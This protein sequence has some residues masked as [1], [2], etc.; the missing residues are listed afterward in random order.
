LLKSDA[1]TDSP[2]SM[3]T[4]HSCGERSPQL[5]ARK[6]VSSDEGSRPGIGGSTA[7][8]QSRAGKRSRGRM[9]LQLGLMELFAPWFAL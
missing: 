1:I 5:P 6:R 2:P 9:W 3:T 8:G 7:T 4:P